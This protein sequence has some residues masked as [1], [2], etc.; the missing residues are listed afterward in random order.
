MFP[1]TKDYFIIFNGARNK[2][3]PG[4]VPHAFCHWERILCQG[5]P[6]QKERLGR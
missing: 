2:L 4:Q 5:R 1:F 6:G 3:K